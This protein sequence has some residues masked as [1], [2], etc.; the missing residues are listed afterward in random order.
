MRVRLK[1]MLVV[2]TLQ[3]VGEG[4][5]DFSSGY[6]VLVQAMGVV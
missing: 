3:L 6:I 2:L 1:G 4:F 5:A